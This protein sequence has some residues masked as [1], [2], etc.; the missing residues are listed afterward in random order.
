MNDTNEYTLSEMELEEIRAYAAPMQELNKLMGAALRM[1]VR[2]QKL[3]GEWHLN[4]EGTKLVR[5]DK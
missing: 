5:G 1:L 3:Q 2:Q 4:A